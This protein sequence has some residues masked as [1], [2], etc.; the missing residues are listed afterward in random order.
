MCGIDRPMYACNPTIGPLE[1]YVPFSA[2]LVTNF[3]LRT[4]QLVLCYNL[5]MAV[6][7]AMNISPAAIC[8]TAKLHT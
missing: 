1:C 2:A 5:V 7:H 6:G 8:Q 3:L 4:W